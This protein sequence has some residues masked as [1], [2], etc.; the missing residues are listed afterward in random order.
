LFTNSNLNA[1]SLGEFAGL[2]IAGVLNLKDA[3]M[4][5]ATRERLIMEKCKIESSGMVAVSL[6]PVKLQTL[7]ESQQEFF[8]LSIACYNSPTDCVVSGPLPQLTKLKTILDTKSVKNSQLSVSYGYHS[9]AMVPVIDDLRVLSRKIKTQVPS[10]PV[11]S[12]VLG[13]VVLPGDISSFNIDYF[14]RHCAEPVKFTQGIYSY[15]SNANLFCCGTIWIELSPHPQILPMLQK[16]PDLSDSMFLSSLRKGQDSWSAMSATLCSLYLTDQSLDW[17]R[18]FGQLGS[19]SCV[20]LPSYP[21]SKKRFWVPFREEAA[22]SMAGTQAKDSIIHDWVQLPGTD[23]GNIAIFEIPMTRIERYMKGHCVA[24]SPLCPASV[25][26]EF[27]IAGVILTTK[28]LAKYHDDLHVALQQIHF[29]KALTSAF[30]NEGNVMIKVVIETESGTFSIGSGL[31]RFDSQTVHAYG[32]YQLQSAS[33]LADKLARN[34]TS[35]PQVLKLGKAHCSE[36]FSARTV[37]EVIFP[38]VVEYSKEFQTVEFLE[39]NSDGMG[40]TATIALGSVCDRRSFVI[41]PIF[42]DTLLHVVGF[43]SNLRGSLHEAYICDEIELVEFLPSYIQSG[44]RFVIHCNISWISEKH[45]ILGESFAVTEAYPRTVVAHMKG[46]RFRRVRLGSLKAGLANSMEVS[47]SSLE[48][49]SPALSRDIQSNEQKVL[50]I[51]ARTCDI[52]LNAGDITLASD[53]DLLG[54]DSLM[55]LEL[56][57]ELARAFPTIGDIENILKCNNT[58]DIVDMISSGNTIFPDNVIDEMSFYTSPSATSSSSTLVLEVD[59]KCPL[60]RM[61]AEILE[62]EQSVITDNQDLTY[63]GLDSLA[64]MEAIYRIKKE[65]NLHLSAT[66]FEVNRTIHDIHASIQETLKS[67]PINDRLNTQLAVNNNKRSPVKGRLADTLNLDRKLVPLQ[68]SPGNETPLVLIHDG[69]GLTISYRCIAELNRDVW[70]INNPRFA[71][72]SEG[73]WE[74]VLEMA[75]SY[76]EYILDKL[77]VKGSGSLI[78]GG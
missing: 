32:E 7:L 57:V 12:T 45:A 58:M 68:Q 28:H 26:L 44:S 54:I 29:T 43:I 50:Q 52:N 31:S 38:R 64:S 15:V 20:S 39:I 76:A 75:E 23:N 61:L 41:D 3:L 10:L 11:I 59:R 34:I 56:G 5:I 9:P 35:I 36:S 24:G 18:V 49:T 4:F 1:Y 74:S 19:T 25:Y 21:F 48:P 72:S 27:V 46:I 66:F 71:A 47:Y 73:P 60:R 30:I 65:Y 37:Y 69:S 2:V 78:L 77:Q 42:L 6:E 16:F 8:H 22:P 62:I 33:N 63:L 17:R 55:R 13:R 40:A 14:V 53:L 70:G 51:I 67:S